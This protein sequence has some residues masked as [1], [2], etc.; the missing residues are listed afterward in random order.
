MAFEVS[1]AREARDLQVSLNDDLTKNSSGMLALLN[2]SERYLTVSCGHTSQFCKD[3]QAGCIMPEAN[4]A[5]KSGRLSIDNVAKND[6]KFRSTISKGW[7]WVVMPWQV[8][9]SIITA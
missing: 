4:L 3:A 8:P 2:G 9:S 7:T 6:P 1:P 5:D